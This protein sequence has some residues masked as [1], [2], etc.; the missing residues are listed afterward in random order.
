MRAERP[1]ECQHDGEDEADLQPSVE[2]HESVSGSKALWADERRHEIDAER[3]RNGETNDRFEHG[4]TS[5]PGNQARIERKDAEGQK[6]HGEKDDVEHSSTSL[7][8][9]PGC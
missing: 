1:D 9:V 8:I 2:G 4:H 6:T 7:L 5:D 3:E